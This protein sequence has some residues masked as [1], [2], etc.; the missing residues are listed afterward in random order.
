[1]MKVAMLGGYSP[2]KPVGGVQVHIGRLAY[3]LSQIEGIELHLITFGS[4]KKVIKTGNLR[5][6]VLRRWLPWY[7]Y[8]PFEVMILRREILKINPDIVHAHESCMPYST[9]AALLSKKF[10][11]LLTVHMVIKEWVK[12]DGESSILT[13]LITLPNEKYVLSKIQNI[14]AVSPYIKDLIG[15]MTQSKVYVVPNG[16]DFG[17]VENIQQY[18]LDGHIIFYMGMLLKVKGVDILIKA[19]PMIKKSIPDVYLLIAGT[20][21]EKT[22]LKNLVNELNI[23]K[24]VKFLSWVSGKEKYSYYKSAD[25]CILPSRFEGFGIALLEAMVCEKPVVA[26][27]VGGIPYIVEDGIIGFLFEPDKVDDLANKMIILLKDEKLR[28]R[29]GD[30]GR[31]KAKEFTWER[32][33]EK[34]M[35][36]YQEVIN[37]Y[38]QERI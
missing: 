33:A 15:D 5:I 29:M 21:E 2:E 3:H 34:T 31:E 13:R 35:Q 16:V 19:I 23:E 11:T 12:L 27:N 30:A 38:A 32:V 14:I 20:G 10:P 24:N 6:H 4:K 8:L 1:M 9:A 36:T 28:K 18:E 37:G 26:S 17:D 25:V 22:N 7:F